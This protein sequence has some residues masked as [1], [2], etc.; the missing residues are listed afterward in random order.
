M[1]QTTDTIDLIRFC[2]STVLEA[3]LHSNAVWR[4][5]EEKA[6]TAQLLRGLLLESPHEKLRE[7]VALAMRGVCRV[8][9]SYV[10]LSVLCICF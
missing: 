1:W 3:S 2:F 9:P 4:Y 8:L 10:R 6:T 5:F 7:G